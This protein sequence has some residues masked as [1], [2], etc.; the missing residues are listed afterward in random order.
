[1]VELG[2]PTVAVDTHVFRVSNRTGLAP[3]KTPEAVE[4]NLM[5]I[6]PEKFGTKA[7]SLLLL[8]GRYTCL[9]QKPKCG[10]CVINKLCSYQDKDRS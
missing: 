4:T 1:M 7:G 10:K 5:K 9:S 8:H 2:K 6:I 3:G